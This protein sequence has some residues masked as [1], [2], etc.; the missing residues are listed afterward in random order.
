MEGWLYIFMFPFRLLFILCSPLLYL[1]NLL[2]VIITIGYIDN[3]DDKKI[4]IIK[5]RGYSLFGWTHS[6]VKSIHRD[7]QWIKCEKDT[8]LYSLCIFYG[9]SL[10][11]TTLIDIIL[12]INGGYPIRTS[13]KYI[14]FSLI[15]P[16]M[17][18]IGLTSGYI[19]S[20]YRYSIKCRLASPFASHKFEYRSR[21]KVVLTVEEEKEKETVK[22]N[23]LG[24]EVLACIERTNNLIDSIDKL[25]PNLDATSQL[26]QP[27]QPPPLN[28]TVDEHPKQ[29]EEERLT[30]ELIMN[31]DVDQHIT[32]NVLYNNEL[33]KTEQWLVHDAAF[34]HLLEYGKEWE[35]YIIERQK[36]KK[37]FLNT[38]EGSNE[39]TKWKHYI[40]LLQNNLI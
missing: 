38:Q 36:F 40:K 32:V 27:E 1:T 39:H 6:R 18:F 5:N 3:D 17:I 34:I 15:T 21:K 26:S 19:I 13:I 24:D 31:K 11:I 14:V 8:L 22:V 12:F 25:I 16:F 20:H 4:H 30:L 35:S 37:L 2:K 9:I 10:T 28:V 7:D 29:D 33:K 23:Q